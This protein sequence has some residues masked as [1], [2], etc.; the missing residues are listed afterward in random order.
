MEVSRVAQTSPLHTSSPTTVFRHPISHIIIQLSEI[1]SGPRS[2]PRPRSSP[3]QCTPA[4]AHCVTQTP[5][6]ATPDGPQRRQ[7][8]RANGAAPAAARRYR[9]DADAAAHRSPHRDASDASTCEYRRGMAHFNAFICLPSQR[10]RRRRRRRWRRWRRQSGW[11]GRGLFTTFSCNA[12][13]ARFVAARCAV[14]FD[15]ARHKAPVSYCHVGIFRAA[16]LHGLWHGAGNRPA[17]VA[18]EAMWRTGGACSG[19]VVN[20]SNRFT[21]DTSRAPAACVALVAAE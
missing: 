3:V 16:P 11:E 19:T 17:F 14:S 20:C 6:P 4:A 2:S 1:G 15:R 10:R 8:C 18:A 9:V 21:V 7:L 13:P 12:H 5:P